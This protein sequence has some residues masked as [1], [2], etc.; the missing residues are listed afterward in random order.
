MI[1]L[2]INDIYY[3]N[4]CSEIDRRKSDKPLDNTNVFA[5]LSIYSNVIIDRFFEHIIEKEDLIDF[6]KDSISVD[7]VSIKFKKV[8]KKLVKEYPLIFTTAL[9]REIIKNLQITFEF[10][11]WYRDKRD[12]DSLHNLVLGFIKIINIKDMIKL[13]VDEV[14]KSYFSPQ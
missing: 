12:K 14:V 8:F 4:V 11:K 6:F 10:H 2:Y 1:Y 9:T 5:P 13:S 7:H 3:N